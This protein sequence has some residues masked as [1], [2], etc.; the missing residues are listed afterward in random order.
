M[1]NIKKNVCVCVCVCVC[2]YNRVTLLYRSNP[3]KYSPE[4]KETKEN[5]L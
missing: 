4:A 3:A 5:V 1:P 2:V